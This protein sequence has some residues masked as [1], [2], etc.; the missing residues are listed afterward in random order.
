[1]I[2][3]APY[4]ETVEIVD[5]Q[6]A[7]AEAQVCFVGALSSH[8]GYEL[9]LRDGSGGG[10]GCVAVVDTRDVAVPA[11]LPPLALVRVHGQCRGAGAVRAT[12]LAAVEALDLAAWREALRLRRAVLAR[13][14]LLPPASLGAA[15][16]AAAAAAAAS[17]APPAPPPPLPR[18]RARAAWPAPPPADSD[19]AACSPTASPADDSAPPAAAP[20][21]AAEDLL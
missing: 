16:L 6:C 9:T 18:V 19:A 17:A 4:Y 15:A 11:A 1:M 14:G 10:G 13:Q 20:T 5:L 21:Q 3:E 7:R 2:S 12:V 8:D